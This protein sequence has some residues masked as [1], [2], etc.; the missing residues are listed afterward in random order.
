MI[1]HIVHVKPRVLIIV[2]NQSQ[3]DHSNE[4]YCHYCSS[5]IVAS[6][7]DVVVGPSSIAFWI[8]TLPQFEPTQYDADQSLDECLW[9][10]PLIVGI[11]F[12]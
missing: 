5:L 1:F 8:A 10:D 3:P 12:E 7:G 11:L 4:R 6:S 2:Y 9:S